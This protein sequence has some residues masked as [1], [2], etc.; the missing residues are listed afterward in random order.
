M[1]LL[2]QGAQYAISAIIALSKSTDGN[3]ISASELAKTLNCPAA[4]LS[5]ILAKL[6]EPGIII[7][8]RGLKG[9][10]YLAK[11][12]NEIVLFDVIEAIDGT[13]F[14]TQCFLGI[15]GCGHIEPCPFHE[16]WATK[17]T[18][19]EEWL[20]STSFE[21]VDKSM[22]QDWFEQTLQFTRGMPGS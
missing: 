14:F 1:R 13:Q 6:K 21:Q 3:A 9:G 5:Q 10:V 12:L 20:R 11:P 19:I 8:M 7:S 18:N 17:R 22:T 2:S 15:E 4:Y 16:F